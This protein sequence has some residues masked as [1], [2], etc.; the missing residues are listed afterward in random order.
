VGEQGAGVDLSR[1]AILQAIVAVGIAVGAV[2]AA[3]SVSLKRSLGV[4]PGRH[5]HG[6]HRRLS[7]FYSR[8]IARKDPWRSAQCR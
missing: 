8:A 6:N 5:R 3:A 1:A 7:A 2:Y 4:L